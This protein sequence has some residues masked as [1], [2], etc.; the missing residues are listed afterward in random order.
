MTSTELPPTE[1]HFFADFLN[2]QV[3]DREGRVLGRVHDL[4][5]GL[6]ESYPKASVLVIR[7]G[8]LRSSFAA[9]SWEAIDRILLTVQ[10]SLPLEQVNFEPEYPNLDFTI[11]RDVLDKQVVD[12][13]GQKVIRVNDVHLL[14]VGSEMRISHVDVGIRGIVRRLGWQWWVDPFVQTFLARTDYMKDRLINWR[15]IQPLA[16]NPEKG[17]L[18]LT[19]N[20][21]QLSMIPHADFGA[22]MQE[23]DVHKRLAL[24]NSISADF[25]P[26][27]FSDMPIPMQRELLE[28]TDLKDAAELLSKIPADQST[29]LLEEIPKSVADSL[30]AL[31]ETTQ[32]RRLSALLGYTSDSAGGL[33]TTELVTCPST[34]SVADAVQRLRQTLD[35]LEIVTHVYLIDGENRLTGQVP[36]KRLLLANPSDPV[37]SSAYP[38]PV[39]VRAKDSLREVA[40][41]MEKYKL[42]SIPVVN[43][44]KDRVLQGVITID[45]IL[46]RVIPLAWRRRTRTVGSQP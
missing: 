29:D 25:R 1:F 6:N 22:M 15:F 27:V 11:A 5:L 42:S 2:K 21:K 44:G 33:M 24:F 34:A 10:L 17:R 14:K 41:V 32:A 20:Q 30:L 28:N 4:S 36:L 26:K 12:T 37:A 18:K 43:N 8:R 13:S 31:M 35:S 45:D 39:Y 40:Y 3:I 9:V 16:I 7:S 23:L 38:R 19:I 46:V